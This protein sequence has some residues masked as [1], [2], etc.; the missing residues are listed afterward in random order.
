MWNRSADVPG[1]NLMIRDAIKRVL[2]LPTETVMEYKAHKNAL[3]D[4]SSFRNTD[5]FR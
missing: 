4:H 1:T 2:N 3:V 5:V